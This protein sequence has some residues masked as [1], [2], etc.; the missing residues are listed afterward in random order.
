[1]ICIVVQELGR[2]GELQQL[3]SKR[4]RCLREEECESG[5]GRRALR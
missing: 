3:L 2:I 5:V 4:D 1:M